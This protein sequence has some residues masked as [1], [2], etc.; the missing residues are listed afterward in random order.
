MAVGKKVENNGILIGIRKSLRKIRISNG[1][2]IE[3][4]ITDGE[5]K[6]IIDS[7]IIPEFKKGKYFDGTLQGMLA[8]IGKIK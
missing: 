3:K 5:T 2:G 4:K 8:M 7:I 6:K 1:N